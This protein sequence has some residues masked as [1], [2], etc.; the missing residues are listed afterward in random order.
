MYLNSHPPTEVRVTLDLAEALTDPATGLV[1]S[2]SWYPTGPDD[3]QFVHCH[4]SVQPPGGFAGHAI[5]AG[6]TALAGD[7]ALAKAMGESV[8]R[9]CVNI[10]DPAT[11]NVAKYCDLASIH[12]SGVVVGL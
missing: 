4:T 10:Y 3:P 2:Y 7:I 1:K 11:V 6:G 5:T 9:Y 8:E 12:R